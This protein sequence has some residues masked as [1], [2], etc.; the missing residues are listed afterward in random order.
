[1]AVTATVKMEGQKKLFRK[2]DLIAGVGS[3]GKR[4]AKGIMRKASRAG[5]AVL[6]KKAKRLVPRDK[7]TLHA[8][9]TVKVKQYASGVTVAVIGPRKRF[10][11]TTKKKGTRTLDAFYSHMIEGGTRRHKIPKRKYAGQTLRFLSGNRVITVPEVMH[12]GTKPQPFI[13]PASRAG[14]KPAIAAFGKKLGAEIEKEV[15]K[16]GK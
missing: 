9:L 7:G 16:G 5:G 4:V 15:K 6:R 10:E 1:M 2:L 11:R 13:G 8:A 12:P 14:A 3:K